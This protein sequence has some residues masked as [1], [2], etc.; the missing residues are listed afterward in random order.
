MPYALLVAGYMKMPFSLTP[1]F[2]L[3]ESRC[4]VCDM[5]V[6]DKSYSIDMHMLVT[7]N[8]FRHLW[9][10]IHVDVFEKMCVYVTGLEHA[11]ALRQN[12]DVLREV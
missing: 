11:S 4:R 3:L 10:D 9:D 8:L 5:I 1:C 6:L 2:F 7:K 12:C